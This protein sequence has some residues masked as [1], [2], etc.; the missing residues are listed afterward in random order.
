MLGEIVRV[1]VLS[2][3]RGIGFGVIGRSHRCELGQVRFPEEHGASFSQESNNACIV[4]DEGSYQ[5][6]TPGCCLH[7]IL[8]CDVVLDKERNSM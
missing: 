4:R 5:R 7:F 6:G 3:S 8:G 2:S 1:S